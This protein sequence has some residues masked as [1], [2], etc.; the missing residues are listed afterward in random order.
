MAQNSCIVYLIMNAQVLKAKSRFVC[1]YTNL[2][3]AKFRVVY[4]NIILLILTINTS[5]D[6]C[7]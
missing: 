1:C 4:V 6:M 3:D 7:T 5:T 2:T